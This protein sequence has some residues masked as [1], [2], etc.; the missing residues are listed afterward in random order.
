MNYTI[1]SVSYINLTNH[2]EDD[3][4]SGSEKQQ[5]RA[6]INR[7]KEDF[8]IWLQTHSDSDDIEDFLTSAELNIMKVRLLILVTR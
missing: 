6:K 3:N 5:R 4:P 2:G 1:N 8:G 7:L